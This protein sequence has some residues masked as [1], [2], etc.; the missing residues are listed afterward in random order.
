MVTYEHPNTPTPQK[1]TPRQT[2]AIPIRD[3]RLQLQE[4]Q[5]TPLEEIG[6]LDVDAAEDVGVSVELVGGMELAGERVL[7]GRE[8]DI[9]GGKGEH[10]VSGEVG[11]G[12]ADRERVGAVDAGNGEAGH[13]PSWRSQMSHGQPQSRPHG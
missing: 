2:L 5:S 8:P 11:G 9:E 6:G 13:A 4:A 7:E 1:H 3:V 12:G 10:G